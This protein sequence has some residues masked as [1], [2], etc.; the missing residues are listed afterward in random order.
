MYKEEAKG[1]KSMEAIPKLKSLSFN[2]INPKDLYEM[3]LFSQVEEQIK[4]FFKKSTKYL[5]NMKSKF[6]NAFGN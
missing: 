6:E 5:G 4:D 1:S 3:G 2:I